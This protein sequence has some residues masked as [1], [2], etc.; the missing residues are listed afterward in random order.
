[1]TTT[2][3][4]GM[5]SRPFSEEIRDQIRHAESLYHRLVLVVGPPGAGKT[6]AL[7]AVA[8]DTGAP[9]VNVNLEL[10]RGMLDL[11]EQQRPLRVQPL[12]D[13]MLAET[14]SR[15]VLLDNTEMLFDVSLKQDPLRLLQGLSRRRTVAAT[16]CGSLQD[17]QIVYAT[18][19]HPEHRRHPVDG[20]LV[21]SRE[22]SR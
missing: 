18:P 13:A 20:T 2:T 12:L 7:Q 10:A 6:N 22:A 5:V 14:D 11:T 3:T 8:Q 4:E 16:W 21:A 19:G 1:M 15:L 17:N 9:L